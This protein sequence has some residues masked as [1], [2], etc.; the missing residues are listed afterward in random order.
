MSTDLTSPSVEPADRAL[1]AAAL[2]AALERE[3]PSAIALRHLLHAEPRVSGDEGETVDA[4][5]DALPAGVT[6]ERLPGHAAV[7]RLGPPG[8]AVALRAE[9]D[10]LP[11]TEETGL[12]WTADNGAM[13]ACG[14]D[15]HMAAVVAVFRAA[16]TL[17]PELPLVLVCQPREET[18]PSGAYD[19]HSAGVLKRHDVHTVIG[20][21]LQPV[22]PAGTVACAAGVVNASSD[23]FTVT[24]SGVAGHGAYPHLTRD[25]V[26]AASHF[27]VGLQQLASRD[28][29]PMI[30]TVVTAGTIDTDGSAN[31]VPARVLVRG[32]LRTMD[33][34]QRTALRARVREIADGIA[35]AHGCQAATEFS[36]G[37]PELVNDPRLAAA[38]ARRL[39]AAGVTV[40]SDLRSCGADDF[41][42]F[43]Q[44]HAG[45][46]LF[47]GTGPGGP[48]APRLHSSTFAPPDEAVRDVAAA[49]AHAL[50]EG[51]S[52]PAP[53]TPAPDTPVPVQPPRA[54]PALHREPGTHH[55]TPE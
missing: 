46:M 21:H 22:L 8:P 45:L 25:P 50:L 5:L 19:I 39:A 36:V 32:T 12:P 40:N 2:F 11:L 51:F 48:N 10:A 34:D 13:H 44:S 20:A 9:L 54:R 3:L 23:E 55:F 42:Y 14:H 30:P 47:V 18:Y 52:A 1:D 43:C 49:L 41:A 24:M 38:T 33:A 15:V 17:W 37:E 35:L 29:D 28:A 6:V 26:L 27:V 53:D 4:L 16:A 31:V 7:A